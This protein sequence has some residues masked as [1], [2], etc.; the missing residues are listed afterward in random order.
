MR[1]HIIAV[2][3][4]AAAA[5]PSAW[6]APSPAAAVPRP[7]VIRPGLI[8]LGLNLGQPTGISAKAWLDKAGAIEVIAAWDFTRAAVTG[9]LDYHLVFPDLLKVPPLTFP[10]FVG[11]GGIVDV[12]AAGGSPPVTVG[13]RV[14]VGI[15]FLFQRVPIEVSIEVVPGIELF[16]VTTMTAGGGLGLRY[17]F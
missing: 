6:G 11:L 9:S 17:C 7:N 3:L 5:M 2:V 13:L 14:P 15:L 10:V 8:E 1:R 16:P 4:A 12:A